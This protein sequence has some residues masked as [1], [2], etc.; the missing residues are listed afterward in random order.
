LIA[1]DLLGLTLAYVVATHRWGGK[2]T[3]GST[4]ELILFLVSLPCWVLVAKLQ[5]L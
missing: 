1:A 3:L 5:G 4:R 2:G